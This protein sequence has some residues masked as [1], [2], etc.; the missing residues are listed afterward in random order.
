MR[1]NQKPR[2]FRRPFTSV[3][4]HIFDREFSETVPIHDNAQH[5]NDKP[6][7][8]G[9]DESADWVERANMNQE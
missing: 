5:G 7:V 8:M 1:E 6:V 2:F 9:D 3:K 4:Y